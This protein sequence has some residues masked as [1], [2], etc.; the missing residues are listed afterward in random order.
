MFCLVFGEVAC[1]DDDYLP[2]GV[3]QQLVVPSVPFAVAVDFRLPERCVGLGQ[4]ELSASLINNVFYV[5]SANSRGVLTP[6]TIHRMLFRY[7]CYAS[8]ETAV[9]ENR[10]SVS[11]HHYVRLARHTLDVQP[12]PVSVRPQP[13]PDRY[14]RLCRLAAYVRHAAVALGRCQ[15]I[16]H[17][18]GVYLNIGNC[19]NFNLCLYY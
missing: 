5:C 1:P 19:D 12:V 9:D 4:Y 3:K 15:N 18:I 16:G 8:S 17:G 14:L 7:A 6:H 13:F 2:T 11:A 10:R